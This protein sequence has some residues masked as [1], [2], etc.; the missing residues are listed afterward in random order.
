MNELDDS[1]RRRIAV[2]GAGGGIGGAIVRRFVENGAHV[3]ALDL[4]TGA[5][6]IP[7]GVVGSAQ[8]DL[9]DEA[10]VR[11]AI[12]Q[13]ARELGGI[14]VLV[15]SGGII[16]ARKPAQDLSVA[17]W[18][19]VMGVNARGSFL[20]AKYSYPFLANGLSPSLV[21]VASQLGL[22]AVP[23]AAAYCASKG[24]VIQLARSLA[25]DWASAGISVNAI[26]PGPTATSMV[27]SRIEASEDPDRERAA[28]MNSTLIRRLVEP[29]EIAM[30]VATLA[31]PG[32]G[33]LTG[34]VLV[35]DGGY[36]AV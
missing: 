5:N 6:A 34:S 21:L 28:L 26:C 20:L 23:R 19:E 24:A 3:M 35:I 33:S 11:D 36:T 29:D 17:D 30:L 2:V 7:S 15:N 18:D 25:I 14:D 16:R 13:A 32:L 31:R 10:S 8:C 27:E 4:A 1:V 12:A 9:T 22:V